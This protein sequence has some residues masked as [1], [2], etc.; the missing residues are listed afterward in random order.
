MRLE[1]NTNLSF[2]DRVL[3]V[4]KEIL[5]EY[6]L[7]EKEKAIEAASLISPIDDKITND[8]KFERYYFILKTIDRENEEFSHVFNDAFNVYE[9]G[10]EKE[11]NNNIMN[12]IIEYASYNTNIFPEITDYYLFLKIMFNFFEINFIW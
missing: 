7:I 2:E 11:I 1:Y 10:L 3:L 6:P 4:S 12:D 9:A 8:D 5:D